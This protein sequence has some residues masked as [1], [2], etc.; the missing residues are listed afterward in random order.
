MSDPTPNLPRPS[1]TLGWRFLIAG[2]FAATFAA[3]GFA[4]SV[5]PAAAQI[6]A[7]MGGG[8]EDG[9]G[10]MGMHGRHGAGHAIM[11]ARLDKFL[12]EVGASADQ[13]AR[14]HQILGD[15]M[16]AVQ[17]IHERMGEAHRQFFAML[18]G[19]T[20]DR[21]GLEQLRAARIADI[22]QASKALVASFAEAAQVLS[23][24]QRAKL[25]AIMAERH[26][27]RPVERSGA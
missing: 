8:M 4:V 12:D 21:A 27:E 10:G 3:G 24:D 9:M 25:A 18:L 5:I 22:D 7:A 2:A 14:I 26:R 6:G 20:I 13:K 16:K 23:P 1:R 15:G 19:P 11:V 17:P